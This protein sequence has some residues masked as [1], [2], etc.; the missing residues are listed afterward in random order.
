MLP[1]N[2]PRMRKILPVIR[3]PSSS[4]HPTNQPRRYVSDFSQLYASGQFVDESDEE[5]RCGM[6]CMMVVWIRLYM[7]LK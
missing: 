7:K 6:E 2:G 4:T 3:R 5:R 1:L